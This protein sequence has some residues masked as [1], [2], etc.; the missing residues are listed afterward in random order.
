MFQQLSDSPT[1]ACNDN[2]SFFRRRGHAAPL[3]SGFLHAVSE[4]AGPICLNY[5][6]PGVFLIS[7]QE[8]ASTPVHRRR[9]RAA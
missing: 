1:P 7:G 4:A 6:A 2:G 9:A 8:P 3:P 5:I